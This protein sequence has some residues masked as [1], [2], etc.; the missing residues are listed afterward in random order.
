MGV[1]ILVRHGES[2]TNVRNLISSDYDGYPLT[3]TGRRQVAS[4]SE[5]F[6]GIYLDS[7]YTS[8]VQR[9]RETAQIISGSIGLNPV[10]DER[11]KESGMGKY[12]NRTLTDIPKLRRSD[13]GMETWESHQERFLGALEGIEG[14]TMLVSHAFPIRAALSYYL[15][16]NEDESYGINIRNASISVI[17]LDK[18]EVLCIGS[19]HLTQR[20]REQITHGKL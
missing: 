17:D 9:A 4:A 7:F 13:L 6:R 18:E 2:E 19:R 10:V 1:A 14:V 12:N 3:E 15:D 5:Q 20:V 11:I 16:M 8:P